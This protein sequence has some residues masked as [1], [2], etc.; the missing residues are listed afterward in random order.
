MQGLNVEATNNEGETALMRSA[1]FR[2][3]DIIELLLAK[4]AS[5]YST[6]NFGT[7]A[8]AVAEGEGY[9]QI[10]ELLKSAISKLV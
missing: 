5:P 10:V 2:R 3:K 1:L 8:L 9:T 7:T 6:D 4:G